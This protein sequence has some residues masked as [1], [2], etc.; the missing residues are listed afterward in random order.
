M[1]VLLGANVELT[2]ALED[3]DVSAVKTDDVADLADDG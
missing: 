1:W 3:A 2:V